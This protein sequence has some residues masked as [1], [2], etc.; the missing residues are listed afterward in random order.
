MYTSGTTGVPK[1]SMIRHYSVLRTVRNVNYMEM[2]SDDSILYT[3]AI[4]FD[5][6][7]YE[8]WGALLSGYSI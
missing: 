5:V 2:T 8:I 7:T 4:V 3:S 6:T 1:G